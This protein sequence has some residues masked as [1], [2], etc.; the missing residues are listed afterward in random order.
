MEQKWNGNGMENKWITVVEVKIKWNGTEME[1]KWNGEI[2]AYNYINKWFWKWN[3]M[4]LEKEWNI[5]IQGV[6]CFHRK[7]LTFSP[8]P[9]GTVPSN[10]IPFHGIPLSI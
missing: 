4:E 1:W 9:L 6:E 10:S 3:G 8:I 2:E 7:V 5:R